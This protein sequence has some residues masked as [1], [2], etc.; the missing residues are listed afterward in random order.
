[1]TPLLLS[2]SDLTPLNTLGLLDPVHVLDC[3]G[4][5]MLK[6]LQSGLHPVQPT[7]YDFIRMATEPALLEAQSEEPEPGISEIAQVVRHAMYRP[8]R[9]ERLVDRV[10]DFFVFLPG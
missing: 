6:I 9:G 8:D 3:A 7:R 5:P 1:M 4:L 10:W 2:R